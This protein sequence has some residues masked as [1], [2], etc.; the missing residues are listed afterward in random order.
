[1]AD[2]AGH[3]ESFLK[4]DRQVVVAALAIVVVLAW[5]YTIAGVGMDMTAVEMTFPGI[6][7]SG[8]AAAGMD[9]DMSM[10]APVV[11]AAYLV[12]ML[13][14]WWIMM[15][16]MML[17]SAAPTIL[18]A[19]ALN[20]RSQSSVPPFGRT[21]W[22]T[23]GYL[24]AWLA[25]SLVATGMHVVLDQLGLISMLMQL[26]SRWLAGAILVA[27]GV[28][29]FTPLKDTCLRHCRSPIAFLTMHRRPG[30]AGALRMGMS[31]GAYCLGCCWFLMLLLFAGGVMNLLLIGALAL[32]VLAEKTL[33][34]GPVAGRVLGGLLVVGGMWLL[35]S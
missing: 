21:T 7:S 13:L 12:A 18:L 35:A 33:P 10:P 1:M 28:W 3:I 5:S 34:R 8:S 23:S 17:P 2:G 22:F 16:A 29:Q 27:A 6:L 19:A 14:M 25:F 26:K 20:R 11:D 32:V 9:L 4:R 30:N 24:L 15:I 31:H